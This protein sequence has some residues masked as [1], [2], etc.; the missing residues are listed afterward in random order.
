[1]ALIFVP[2]PL[3]MDAKGQLLPEE[4]QWLFPAPKATS[5]GSWCEPDTDVTRD[6]NLVEMYDIGLQTKL[7]E[8]RS[9]IAAADA[10]IRGRKP[11]PPRPPMRNAGRSPSNGPSMQKTRGAYVDSASGCSADQ[12]R[13][14]PTRATSS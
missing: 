8:S 7:G 12:R 2:Y 4:R 10:K 11:R 13:P 5:N 6:Q 14:E 9:Q 1:M 3:K